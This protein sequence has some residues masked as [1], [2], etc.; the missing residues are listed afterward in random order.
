MQEARLA[1][2]ARAA[3]PSSQGAQIALGREAPP[4]LQALATDGEQIKYLVVSAQNCTIGDNGITINQFGVVPLQWRRPE[5]FQRNL[6]ENAVGRRAELADLRRALETAGSTAVIGKGVD[7]GVSGALHGLPGVGKSTLAAMYAEAYAA[8]YPGGVL[9]LRLT[10]DMTTAESVGPELSRVA[11]YAYSMDVQAYRLFVAA[12]QLPGANPAAALAGA[13]FAPE[14]VRGLLADHGRL[15]LVA[16]NVWE[17]AALTPIRA[18]LPIDAHLLVTTRDERVA[19]DVG[20][21][22]E[23]DV[24]SVPDALGL[25][26][27]VIPDLSPALAGRL[28]QAVGRHPLA[29]EIAVGD[30]ASHGPDEWAG[31]VARLEADMTLGLA[32][33]G[34][35]LDDDLT[36]VRRLEIVL[37]YSYDALGRAPDGATLQRHFRAV[38]CLA[39]EANFAT[40]AAAAFWEE[41]EVAAQAQLNIFA[42]RSLLRR[43][44]GGRWRQHAI[45]RGFALQQQGATERDR[46]PERHARH[47]LAAMAAADD[48]QRY[49]IMAPDLPNL[50]HAF[51]WALQE[52]LDT[53]QALLSNCADLLRSQNLGAEYLRWA[54]RVLA[55]AQHSGSPR[56]L[57][58]A[59]LS[60]GN[61]LQAAATLVVGEDRGARL[62]QAL[63]AYDEALHMRRDVPLDYATTQN[64]RAVLLRDLAS[65][66]GEP[67]RRL[68]A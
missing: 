44:A 16:D 30:L 5:E 41:N 29:L 9:W 66:P 14:I 28:A 1:R 18:A 27:Q 3:P 52:S 11:A 33:D 32:L 20:R 12:Q 6:T 57:G 65:L 58:Q 36:R 50:R 8:D 61:A 7:R 34:A 26:A 21:P 42:A 38:G 53:A 35:P 59:L 51:T 64:N 67:P 19:R 63:A 13:H 22:M 54:D 40:D 56:A 24:L 68:A 4:G 37:R 15:L 2:H 48:A 60:R 43:Q 46:W 39:Y 10:P 17:R 31:L 25:V 62:R 55:Q 23:L 49:Y 47:Y 45:L